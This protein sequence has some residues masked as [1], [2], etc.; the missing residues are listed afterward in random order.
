MKRMLG[1]G[2]ILAVALGLATTGQAEAYEPPAR[3]QMRLE[4]QIQANLQNDRDLANNHID[5]TVADGVAT[6]KGTVDSDLERDKAV[7]LAGIG[8]VRIVDDQLKVGSAGVKATV[9]DSAITT[10]IKSQLLANTDLRHADISVTTNNGVVT[11]S[12]AVPSDEL[13]RLAVDLARHTG[14]VNRVDD[15]MRVIGGPASAPP[16]PPSR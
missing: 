6:L 15:Q 11:M 9:E 1:V 14:G 8:G 10:K 7:R 12:G 13:R 3:E 5:V 2:G 4:K 16:L